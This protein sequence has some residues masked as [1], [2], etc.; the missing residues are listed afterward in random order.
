M[1]RWVGACSA[2]VAPLVDALRRY[3]LAGGKVHANDTPVSVLAPRQWPNQNGS[4]IAYIRDDRNSGSADPPAVWFVYT[5]N[6]QGL[7]PQS[8]LAG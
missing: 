4:A 3:V 6:R 7:Q 1:A 8:H 2:L 5:L